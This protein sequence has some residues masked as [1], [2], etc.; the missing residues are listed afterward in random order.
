MTYATFTLAEKPEFATQ[1]DRLDDNSWPEF[2]FHND[3]HHWHALFEIFL[4]YQVLFCEGDTLIAGGHTIPIVWDGTVDDLPDTIEDILLRAIAAHEASI[5]CNTQVAVAAM[6]S[7]DHRGQGLSSA[8]LK[9][10]K[11]VGAANGLASLIVPVRPTL[12]PRYPLIPMEAYAAWQRDDGLPYDPWLRVHARLG[13]R[14]LA[15][16]PCTLTV[17]GTVA[18]WESWTNQPLPGSGDYVVAGALQPVH[19]DREKDNGRY[20]DP[21]VW[22]KHQIQ[23]LAARNTIPES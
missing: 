21:N 17:T 4:E 14:T 9:A 18:E 23:K 7:A 2:L 10:M 5:T 19:I 12:K 15:I 3:I 16:A 22:V 11:V 20:E 13:A 8:L 6:V 1:L